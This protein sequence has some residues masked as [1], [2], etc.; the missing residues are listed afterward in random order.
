LRIVNRKY[1]REGMRDKVI[2]KYECIKCDFNHVSDSRSLYMN[3]PRCRIK[4][5]KSKMQLAL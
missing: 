4:Y 2:Y 3:C 1:Y 5:V